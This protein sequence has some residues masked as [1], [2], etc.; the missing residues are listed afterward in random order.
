MRGFLKLAAAVLGFQ[1]AGTLVAAAHEGH[2]HDAPPPPVSTTVAPRMEASSGDFELVA[3]SGSS[4]VVIYLDAFRSNEPVN[5]AEIDVDT[6]GET[7]RASATGDG[8]YVVKPK[9]AGS[10]GDHDLAFTIQANGL[11]DV[12]TGTLSIPPPPA[13]PPE[14]EQILSG[15][16]PPGVVAAARD[17]IAKA[18][19]ASV[20]GLIGIQRSEMA[21]SGS[22]VGFIDMILAPRSLA[23]KICFRLPRV[24]PE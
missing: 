14:A 17:R 22:I 15:F 11:I 8:I 4:E 1:I 23:S 19:A 2:D 12:L 21:T 6:A 24:L 16:L 13:A 10:P 5:A 20:P 3:I 18:R 9:W 7:L